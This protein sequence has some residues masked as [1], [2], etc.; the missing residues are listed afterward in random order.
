MTDNYCSQKVGGTSGVDEKGH[1]WPEGQK[2][3]VFDGAWWILYIS[4]TRISISV[5]NKWRIE[6][7]KGFRIWPELHSWYVKAKCVTQVCVTPKH[8]SGQIIF[9]KIRGFW[10]HLLLREE[11]PVSSEAEYSQSKH[12][13]HSEE[14]PAKRG[15]FERLSCLQLCVFLYWAN[16]EMYLITWRW[17][18]PLQILLESLVLCDLGRVDPRQEA[19]LLN[20]LKMLHIFT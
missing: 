15:R 14:N 16:R 5:L 1:R 19:D 9:K 11:K 8:W 20:T 12:R 13:T 10:S 7:P 2:T 3:L 18:F 17:H 6:I 4:F